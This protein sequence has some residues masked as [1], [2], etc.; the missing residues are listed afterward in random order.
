MR[1]RRQ[2]RG[3]KGLRDIKTTARNGKVVDVVAVL[4]S[5]DVLMV[6]AGGKIQ[7]VRAGDIS[8]VGRNTQGVRVIRLDKDDTLVSMARIPSEVLEGDAEGEATPE[9][10]SPPAG[11]ETTPE[12]DLPSAES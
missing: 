12:S 4:D 1:Y 8:Q 10:D 11:D 3:G 9:T 5:D 6:T 2:K 7:R